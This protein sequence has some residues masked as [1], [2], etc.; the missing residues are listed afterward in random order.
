[1]TIC[2]TSNMQSYDELLSLHS[3]CLTAA[4]Q[5]SPLIL[6]L[7]PLSFLV[8]TIKAVHEMAILDL[9]NFSPSVH[10]LYMSQNPNS[11]HN[12]LPLVQKVLFHFILRSTHGH[13]K[14]E[15]H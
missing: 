10:I 14:H 12:V 6:V 15:A 11:I 7:Q 8:S 13:N 2:A 4:Q 9:K 1:M 3:I 5:H